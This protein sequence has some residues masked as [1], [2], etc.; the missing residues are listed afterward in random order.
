MNIMPENNDW[1]DSEQFERDLLNAYFHFRNNLPMK[2]ADTINRYMVEH[3]YQV[4]TQPD[5]TVAWAIW[6]RVVRPDSLV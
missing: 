4:A 5:G 3:D 1:F 2:D 6:E